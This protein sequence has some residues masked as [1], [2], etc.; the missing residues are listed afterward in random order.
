MTTSPTRA[1]S[2]FVAVAVIAPAAITAV[3]M[4]LQLAAAPSLPDPVAIHWGAAGTADGWGPAWLTLLMTVAVGL[5]VPWLMAATAVVG[6]RRGDRGPVYRLLAALAVATSAFL[7]TLSTGSVLIQRGIAAAEDAP[8]IL[9]VLVLAGFIAVGAGLGG[10]FVQPDERPT[11]AART[12]TMDPPL[13]ATERAVWVRSVR[14]AKG[15]FLVLGAALLLL[16]VVSALAIAASDDAAV[17]ATLIVVVLVLIALIA[18]TAVFRVRVDAAGLAVTSAIGF[19]R[20]RIPVDEIDRVEVVEVSPMG[21]YG[22]WG[23]R[24]APGGGFGVVLRSGPG[25]RV[26]RTGGKVFTVTVDDAETGAALLS[27]EC[28][29]TERE[30]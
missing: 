28:E 19:P 7:G 21:E 18:M 12:A 13:G 16:V 22:G 10:W 20:V 30:R 5:G 14:L 8:S 6:L 4:G 24:W 29:R 25:I 15:G 26:H 2:R 9:P 1:V 27:A 23:L 3:A 17:I 11:R